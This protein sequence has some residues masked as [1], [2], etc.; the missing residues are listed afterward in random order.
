MKNISILSKFILL[1]TYFIIEKKLKGYI[2]TFYGAVS[3]VGRA[4]PF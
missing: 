1:D 4:L 2:N 3:S